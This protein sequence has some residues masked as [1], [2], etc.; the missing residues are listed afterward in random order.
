MD[1]SEVPECS[2][3]LFS[4]YF[5]YLTIHNIKAG[6][7]ASGQSHVFMMQS[8][9]ACHASCITFSSNIFVAIKYFKAK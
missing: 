9:K 6:A 2:I 7:R 4:G 3:L 8:L 1:P 5:V